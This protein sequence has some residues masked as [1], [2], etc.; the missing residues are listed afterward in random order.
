MGLMVRTPSRSRRSTRRHG[1]GALYR[2]ALARLRP[3]TIWAIACEADL[4]VDGARHLRGILHHDGAILRFTTW[5]GVQRF[6]GC[7]LE[8]DWQLDEA[9]E[10]LRLHHRASTVA[11]RDPQALATLTDDVPPFAVAGSWAPLADLAEWM[12][13]WR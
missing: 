5:G 10:E 2:D 4:G 6:V 11:F 1:D 9:A 13:T 8:L 12:E 7:P 3:D